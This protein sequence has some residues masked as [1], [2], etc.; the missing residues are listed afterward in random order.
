LRNIIL[1]RMTGNVVIWQ[2][3]CPYVC[4]T[5]QRRKTHA[6]W[7]ISWHYRMYNVIDEVSHA[8]SSL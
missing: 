5:K 7:G 1:E 2:A 4:R 8:P 3:G 6:L